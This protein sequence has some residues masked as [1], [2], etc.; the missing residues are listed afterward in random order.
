MTPPRWK[1][2]VTVA[3]IIVRQDADGVRY[4]LIEEHTPEGLRLLKACRPVVEALQAQILA[5]LSVVV[6]GGLVTST[7]LNLLVVP[8]GFLLLFHDRPLAARTDD[9][10][11]LAP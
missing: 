7:L 4:L 5:P 2:S 1:P 9:A 10:D 6:L 11:L 8:A 3:A